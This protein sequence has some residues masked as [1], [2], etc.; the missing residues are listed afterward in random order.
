V[1]P[2]WER[3]QDPHLHRPLL[4]S[5]S[6]CLCSG[7]LPSIIHFSTTL[8]RSI[9]LTST[10]TPHS[11][12]IR[13]P[14]RCL[15]IPHRI[16]AFSSHCRCRRRSRPDPAMPPRPIKGTT[17]EFENRVRHT[18]ATAKPKTPN[19]SPQAKHSNGPDAA[20]LRAALEDAVVTPTASPSRKRQ[21]VIYGDRCV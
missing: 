1:F 10:P 18:T 12:H 17:N 8:A 6:Q 3:K 7:S 5:V 14:T 15:L 16:I 13:L 21:K 2:F 9:S 19:G 4:G 20:D 11:I